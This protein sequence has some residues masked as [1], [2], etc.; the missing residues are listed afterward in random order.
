MDKVVSFDP[1]LT[2]LAVWVGSVHTDHMGRTIPIT[3]SID[4]YDIKKSKKP[5]YEAVADVIM[6]NPHMTEPGIKA[7][8]E[9]QSVWNVP[10]RIVGTTVYG[11]M[12]G[13]SVPVCFSGS[14]LKNSAMDMLAGQYGLTLEPKP[15]KSQTKNRSSAVHA[16]NKRNSRAVIL[17]VL[18]A[19]EDIETFE[20]I[21]N[22]RDT[23]GKIKSDDM[24][25]AILLGIGLLV[26]KRTR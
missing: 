13:L 5:S 21:S 26:K 4:K 23:K 16:V 12:R 9:T 10:A 11:V 18:K 22:A 3:H 14:E 2:N 1:G 7:V 15:D 8:V 20:K 25:D 6:S 17:K 19:I 24:T